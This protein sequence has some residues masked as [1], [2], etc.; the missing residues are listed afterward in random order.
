ML[1]ECEKE[2]Q[3]EKHS[4]SLQTLGYII[5]YVELS[6]KGAYLEC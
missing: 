5:D 6:E 3:L 2:C 4:V 1:V